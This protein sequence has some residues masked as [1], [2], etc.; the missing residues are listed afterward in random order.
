MF[1]IVEATFLAPDVKRFRIEA[2]RV[3]RNRQAGQFVIVRVEAEHGERI[4]LTIADSDPTAGTI[5]IIVQGVGKTTKMLNRL[6]AGDSIPDV[7]GPL[8]EPSD[9]QNF[10]TVVVVGGGVGTAIAYPTAVAMKQAGNRVIG[11][12]GARTKELLILEEE[13]AATTDQL[14][15]MT[16]DGSY[17]EQGFVTQKL[18][19]LID[20]GGIDHVLAIGPI[21]MMAAIAEVTRPHGIKTIVSLNPIMVDGTGMCGGCRV[22]VGG[23]S[24]F[25]CVDGPEFDAHDVDFKILTQRNK[26]YRQ[27]EQRSLDE[28]E[29]TTQPELGPCHLQEEHPEV[30]PRVGGV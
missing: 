14:H 9:I 5:T 13:M 15:L 21:P 3:A 19:Q 10:G 26:M 18:Q 23:E 27:R 2:P 11:I 12:V 1:A 4:P 22:T 28:F 6:E 17:G 20:D 24:K 8:G 30:G 7:V 29:M 25:A 16:D